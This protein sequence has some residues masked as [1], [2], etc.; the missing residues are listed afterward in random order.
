MLYGSLLKELL[1]ALAGIGEICFLQLRSEV[2]IKVNPTGAG[3]K[4]KADF[5]NFRLAHTKTEELSINPGR[6]YL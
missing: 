3:K 6:T 5:T 1:P 2:G 4:C